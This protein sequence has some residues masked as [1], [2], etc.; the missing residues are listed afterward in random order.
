MVDSEGREMV[1]VSVIIPAY[2]AMQFLPNTIESVL[3][4]TFGD[5][6]VVI[7]DDGSMDEIAKWVPQIQDSRVKFFSQVNQGPAAARNLGLTKAQGEY[8]A[9]LDADDVWEPTKLEKQVQVLDQYPDVGLVYS[10]VGSIDSQGN[11]CHK[12][13][14]YSFEGDVWEKL[15][16]HNIIE[17]GSTPMLRHSCFETVGMFDPNVKYAQD[18]DMWLR[19]ALKYPFKVIPQTLVYYRNHP[20]NR[21]KNWTIM[22][23]SYHIIFE[24][25]FALATPAQ[26]RF[27]NFAYALAYL[28]IAWKMLQSPTK[29]YQQIASY[30]KRAVAY[31]PQLRYSLP[32]LRFN[33]AVFLVRWLGFDRYDKIRNL[34]HLL[35]RGT[36]GLSK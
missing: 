32:Y 33:L 15:I 27:K 12:V 3:Q 23:P 26:Q 4:Q 7:V 20:S 19:T 6:E 36:L 22:E 28:T 35:R 31:Y 30:R 25:I 24:K 34:S 11:V 10:W 16:E 14:N 8:I 18:W 21:S 9:F 2:N 5:Y 1:K 13:L 29:N 17:C